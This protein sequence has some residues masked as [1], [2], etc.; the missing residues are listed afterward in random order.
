[1]WRGFR[2]G[3]GSSGFEV[4]DSLPT[5]ER[6]LPRHERQADALELDDRSDLLGEGQRSPLPAQLILPLPESFQ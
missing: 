6:S 2:Q 5:P 3:F 4:P 1:M